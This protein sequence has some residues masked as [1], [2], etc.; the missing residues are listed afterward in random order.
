MTGMR[1]RDLATDPEKKN[2]LELNCESKQYFEMDTDR[3][4]ILNWKN[5]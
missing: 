3:M 4:K 5:Y 2:K 1:T